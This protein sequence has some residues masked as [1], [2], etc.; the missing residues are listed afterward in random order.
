MSDSYPV[1]AIK[2]EIER[3]LNP[4]GMSVHDGKVKLDISHVQYVLAEL[5]AALALSEERRK[6]LEKHQF[7]LPISGKGWVCQCCG[8][9]MLVGHAP[10]CALARLIK[11]QE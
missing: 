7:S 8:R 1:G 2:R 9:T 6:L 5:S 4:K 3:A 11:E 10:D